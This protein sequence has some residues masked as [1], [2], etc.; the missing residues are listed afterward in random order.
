MLA[1]HINV[2]R[3]CTVRSSPPSSLVLRTYAFLLLL[4]SQVYTPVEGQRSPCPDVFSYWVEEGTNQPFGYVKLEGLRANQAIT[5]QVDL[6]IAATVSQNNIGSITL[7]KSSTET[8]RDI[9][10]NRPA[11]YRVNFPFRNIKPSVLAIRVNGHTICAGQKVTG[12]IVTTINLQHTLYPSTQSLVSTND[13]TNV[14]VIQY[15][16]P[17]TPVYQTLYDIAP[18]QRLQTTENPPVVT[19]LTTTQAPVTRPVQQQD[20][21]PVKRQRKK[22]EYVKSIEDDSLE[23]ESE[24]LD[25][26]LPDKGF[27]HY[28]IN[29]I[30]AHKG[31]FPWAAPIFHTGSSSKPKYICGSTILTERHLVTAAHCVYNSDGIKQNVSGLTVVPGMH[32]IDNFFE[33]D[34]QERGV[35]KIFVHNDYFFEHGMLVDSDIAVLL[36]DDPIT[37]NKLVRPIC[38]WSDS[39][40]LEKIVGDEGF[41]SGWG[42]TEDGKAKIP[43]YVTAT[44]VERQTC[45]R[46]LELQFAAKARIF[47]ADGHGSVPCTG[48]SGSGFVMKR[49]PRYYIR[50]IVSFGQFD[51]KTLTCAT[52]KYVVYT[53]IAPFRYWLTRVMKSQ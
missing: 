32:N 42:V 43:S 7:Y 18:I 33:A 36:L 46:N 39:D 40:N 14:N 8:V 17:Q 31:M 20:V 4:G 28:S 52:N 5:L 23:Q 3:R 51:P 12:Q 45:N 44:V 13:G 35:K 50:G 29:G 38:M 6:T 47:C 48:D 22:I 15:Q 21:K 49:G 9:Q 30:H 37:Y 11:W 1:V 25:C 53:D 24:S 26:G 19:Q 41:V 34:L 10:N 2:S 27:S 16:P